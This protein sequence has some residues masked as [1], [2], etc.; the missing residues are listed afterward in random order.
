MHDPANFPSRGRGRAALRQPARM[1]ARAKARGPGFARTFGNGGRLPRRLHAPLRSRLGLHAPLRSGLGLCAPLGLHRGLSA[2]FRVICWCLLPAITCL[3][4]TPGGAGQP[5]KEQRIPEGLRADDT[6]PDVYINDSFESADALSRAEWFARRG[7]WSEAAELLQTTVDKAGDKLVLISPGSYVGLREHVANLIADWPDPGL[8]AY[9]A[10]FE[11]EMRAALRAAIA[12]RR[13]DDLLGLFERYFC[14]ES[15]AGLADTIGQLA[16]EAGELALA[17]RVYRRVLEFH[18]N[19][20]K[21]DSRYR[22]VLALITAMRGDQTVSIQDTLQR[23]SIRWMGE[24]RRLGDVVGEL[25]GSFSVGSKRLSPAD[26]PIFGGREQRDRLGTLKV[27]ELALV[28]RFDP[29]GSEAP[30]PEMEGFGTAGQTPEQRAR[31]LNA[32]PV[33]SGDRIFLQRFREIVALRRTTGMEA[34]RFR[35]TEPPFLTLD[36]FEIEQPPGWNSVTVADGRVYASLPGDPISYYSSESVRAAG[37]LICLDAETGG[38]IWRSGQHISDEP[39]SELSFDSTPIVKNGQIFVVGRRLRSFGFEDCY[40]YRFEPDGSVGFR[41]HIG[42]ASTG[43]FGSRRATM[44]IPAMHG[45]TVFVCSNLGSIAAVAA[46]TGAVRWLRLYPRDTENTRWSRWSTRDIYPWQLNPVIFSGGRLICLPTDATNVFVLDAE[47]GRVL[48]SILLADLGELQAILGVDGDLLC[49]VGEQ[50]VC[51][52]LA[53]EELRFASP[54]PEEARLFGRGVWVDDRLLIPTQNGLSAY[55]VS[56]GERTD[57]AWDS[58]Q[59]TGNLLAMPGQLLV[60]GSRALAAYVPKADLWEGLRR[61]M[62]AMPADPAPALEFAEIALR[63]GAVSTAVEVFAEA[64][65]RAEGGDS[66]FPRPLEAAVKRRFFDYAL[67]LVD[68][69]S[70]RGELGGSER[71]RGPKPAARGA[72]MLEELF[73]NAS[74]FAPDRAAHVEYRIR[75]AELFEQMGRVERTLGLYQQILRDRSLCDLAVPTRARPS[76]S[77]P[78]GP[79]SC[80]SLAQGRIAALIDKHGRSIYAPYEAEAGR[81][82]ESGGT[83]GDDAVLARLVAAFPNSNAA[84]RALIAL[85]D[86]EA[87]VGRPQQAA[88]R[89]AQA[90]HR[91][92]KQ[93]DR[94]D[95][96]RKIADAYELAGKVEHAYRW[97]TKAA[98]EHPGALV[99]AS[100]PGGGR[101]SLTFLQYRDRLAGVRAM[102]EPS[103]PDLPVPLQRSYARTFPGPISLLTPLFGDD[104]TSRWSRYFVYAAEGIRALEPKTGADLWESP[105]P[106]RTK[107]E[108]LVARSD[109]AVFATLF[110]VFAVDSA[111]GAYRWVHGS[112]PHDVEPGFNRLE[113]GA[114]YFAEI[115]DWEELETY[116]GFALHGDRLISV[117]TGGLMTCSSISSGEIVWSHRHSPP[118]AGRVQLA[119]PW[120]AYLAA[121]QNH[122]RGRNAEMQKRNDVIYLIDAGTGQWAGS[123]VTDEEY[124][125]EDIFVALD[126]Q[127]IVV[128]SAAVSAYDPRSGKRR[129]QR[130]LEG[131]V[132]RAS[133]MVDVDAVYLSDDGRRVRKLSLD[134]GR[135]LWLS[136][137]LTRASEEDITVQPLV[138]SAP[139]GGRPPDD[140]GAKI[141]SR[142]PVSNRLETARPTWRT[143]PPA[144]TILVSASSS[145]SAVD[146]VTGLVLWQQRAPQ[147]ARFARRMLTKSYVVALDTPQSFQPAPLREHEPNRDR[148][149]AANEPNRDHQ[150]TAYFYDH[151]GASGVIP[152]DGGICNLGGLQD[153]RAAMAVDGA[154]LIQAQKTIHGWVS[155]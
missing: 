29:A 102:V 18:P 81:W 5:V 85:G 80:G 142:N 25:A 96:L 92:P 104:P 44:A 78:T 76:A 57:L 71:P 39:F 129:W 34:W 4:A 151:R 2:R 153:V 152:D 120:I 154:L 118:P 117:T 50:V 15:A 150:G 10:L 109:L 7:L 28:W 135:T 6:Y 133:L 140:A 69:L 49:G 8:G 113:E 87:R 63:G 116:R 58:G 94:P 68:V 122:D 23:A 77:V 147:R 40:L 89:F 11:G 105:A 45:D 82:L 103:Y 126:G 46:N 93:V 60:A 97:L 20:A 99:V 53:T 90:Y 91:Y 61:R 155:E 30:G 59:E 31:R 121:G 41:T 64:V 134:D 65:R 100:A 51:Y 114:A 132:R 98:R 1:L 24:D 48:R 9:R 128:T 33:V 74:G 144:S 62:N 35:A 131:P 139:R 86:R 112:M 141:P 123:V 106:A 37:E 43:T 42:S 145:V 138:A 56:D 22:V 115:T 12:S 26:W 79:D 83:A 32:H 13:V 111:T 47:T 130:P 73:L 75:F 72:D 19:G 67:M 149:G 137:R 84:P 14:T 136:V 107:P 101:R 55:S 3:V 127:I 108:L 125:V 21:H 38:L 36:D 110:E 95:L 88:V 143:S 124:P 66:P 17:Q 16:I 119:D 54:L 52:D 27:D 146:M 148:Q 70:S